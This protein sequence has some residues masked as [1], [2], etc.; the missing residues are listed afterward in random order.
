MRDVVVAGFGVFTAFGFGV[1]AL[2]RGVFAGVP[3]FGPVTRFD[4][5]GCRATVA[6]CAED[7]GTLRQTLLACAGAALAQAGP[8]PLAE[9]AVLI[10]THGDFS[11]ISRFWRHRSGAG[12]APTREQLRDTVP[13]RLTEAVA[14]HVGAGGPRRTYVNGC[15]AA[16]NAVADAATMVGTGRV[17]V[18]LAGGGYLVDAE[19]FARF[20]SGR[21]LSRDASVRPFSADRSGLL[22]GDGCAVLVLAAAEV[23]DRPL[24]RVA[25]W[26]LSSDA[27][28]V[29]QPHPDGAGMA[30]AI[31]ATLDMAGVRP[32][33]V[34]YVNA[35]GTATRLN[36]PA[37]ARA[38]RTALG[39][40]AG[41]IPV[42][43]TKSTTGHCLEA[44][45]AVEA[46]ISLVVL[47]DQILP[48]TAGYTTHDPDCD[49]DCVPNQPRP[50]AVDRVLSLSAAFGGMNAALLFERCHA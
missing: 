50:G 6:A 36:D 3:A 43:S 21:A 22:L 37:E 10:G 28:H 23:V 20:D 18:A 1:Q 34:D 9:A 25:G 11:G 47:E 12:P 31:A 41:T 48:P 16:T 7:A 33:Q 32:S 30:L 45:G 35:H 15:V 26:G 49:L 24:A 19:F 44:A 46:A 2:R 14:T 27:H 17:D 4:T 8:T 29:C 40:A 5:A 38:L 39:D 13:A 42:S